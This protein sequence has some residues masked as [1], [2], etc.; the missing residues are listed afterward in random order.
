MTWHYPVTFDPQGAFM[1]I[2]SVSLVPKEVGSQDPLILYSNRVLPLFV[3]AMAITLRCLQERNTGF[4]PYF[5]YYFHF[6][7]QKRTCL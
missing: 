5:F 1:S 2:C 7:G 3:L 6:R 4:L